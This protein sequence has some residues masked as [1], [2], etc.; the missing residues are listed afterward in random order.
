MVYKKLE[1]AVLKIRKSPRRTVFKSLN[2]YSV[3]RALADLHHKYIITLVDKTTNNLAFICKKFYFV[4]LLEE[5]GVQPGHKGNPTY[6]FISKD[7]NP[8]L[9]KLKNLK[10]PP[11]RPLDKRSKEMQLP[12]MYL[13]PKMHKKP[14]IKFRAIVSS[15]NSPTKPLAKTVCHIL[16]QIYIRNRNYCQ[17]LKSYDGIN[18]MW[19]CTNYLE[20]LSDIDNINKKYCAKS[21][22]VFDFST[23]YT[24]FEHDSLEDN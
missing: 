10:I 1:Q 23:L 13:I 20:I 4:K 12:F 3:K 11:C 7:E 5:V 15:V 19:I 21:F 17:I 9:D 16:K 24:K 8:I 6:E 22:E 14:F 2:N 18:R